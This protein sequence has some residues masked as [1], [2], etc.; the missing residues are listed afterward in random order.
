MSFANLKNQSQTGFAALAKELEKIANPESSSGGA[1]DRLWK[2]TLDK[3]GNGFA[4]IRFLPAPEGEDLPWAKVWSHAFQGTGGWLIDNCLTTVNQKCPVCEHN[5][6]L[7]NSGIES[8]KEIVR[9]QKRKLS[10]YANI[11][12]LQDPAAPEN[13]GKV[14]LYKFG[15]KI[16][17]KIMEAM[18]PAFAD[19]TP[20]NPFDF[21]SGA[22]FKLKIRKVDGYWNYDKSEFANAGV[23][24][25]QPDE[26]LEKIWKKEYSLNEFSDPTN[27]KSYDELKSRLN[28]VLGAPAPRIDRE[29][30]E[31][32]D[33]WNDSRPVSA[34]SF[35]E[36]REPV[37]E[38]VKQPA[39]SASSFSKDEEDDDLSFFA[40]LAQE[41]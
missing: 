41:D 27:F 4:V 29:T 16:F 13:E 6:Q 31:S 19:E 36:T 18:Q 33:D 34:Y 25:N 30:E 10:Y 14:F 15:K 22:D 8:N 17:D 23:L 39:F 3:S 24:G 11:F 28:V 1:D 12:V 37:R 32:E 35:T 20:I 2:P 26:I 7:W 5:S 40:R 21:W 38:Q 9:K